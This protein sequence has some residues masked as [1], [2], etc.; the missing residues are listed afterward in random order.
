MGTTSWILWS[1][2]S[3]AC[4]HSLFKV[5]GIILVQ[6]PVSFSL[7]LSYTWWFGAWSITSTSFFTCICQNFAGHHHV[8]FVFDVA[9]STADWL[10]NLT[11]T[12]ASASASKQTR[13]ID[14]I[15]FVLKLHTSQCSNCNT[16]LEEPLLYSSKCKNTTV[17]FIW[18]TSRQREI[19]DNQKK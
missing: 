10:C 19:E 3:L 11:G 6:A 9:F 12:T 4:W 13:M 5:N 1:H 16:N 2:F 15:A 8:I 14:F 17:A 7:A 18:E